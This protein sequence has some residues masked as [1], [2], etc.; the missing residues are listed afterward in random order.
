MAQTKTIDENGNIYTGMGMNFALVTEASIA[1]GGLTE[2]TTLAGIPLYSAQTSSSGL[3]TISV[4]PSG[5]NETNYNAS[6][7]IAPVELGA[8][9]Q[10][11]GDEGGSEAQ[12]YELEFQQGATTRSQEVRIETPISLIVASVFGDDLSLIHI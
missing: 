2:E 6:I 10:D 4:T 11:I 7:Y 8:A 3:T 9:F 12:E 1:L 5:I